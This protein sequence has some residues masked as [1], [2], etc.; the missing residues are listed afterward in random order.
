VAILK[1]KPKEYRT[2]DAVTAT[3]V[4]DT[5]D[6]AI[7]A[8]KAAEAA[9]SKSDYAEHNSSKAL[10]DAEDAKTEADEAL[11]KSNDI[12]TRAQEG[13]FDGTRL[14]TTLIPLLTPPANARIDDIILNSSDEK[15]EI[16]NINEVEPGEI[17]K[18]TSLSP[19]EAQYAGRLVGGAGGGA[20][21]SDVP[22]TGKA[23]MIW[24]NTTNGVSY[25]WNGTDW[26]G[27]TSVWA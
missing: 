21:Y 24:L 19:F 18:I 12:F 26:V 22:P 8:H 4:N 11:I 20:V 9:F 5:I 14:I 6:T 13:K 10:K 23:G 16:A 17:I 1:E 25:W 27:T 2:G 7:N 3:V 15:L